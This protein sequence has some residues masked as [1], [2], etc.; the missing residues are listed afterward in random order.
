MKTLLHLGDNG[1][2]AEKKYGRKKAGSYGR[3]TSKKQKR[4]ASKAV[5]NLSAL[6]S[7]AMISLLFDPW[8]RDAEPSDKNVT[9][10]EKTTKNEK[11]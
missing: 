3:P 6:R 5:S 11:S 2:T 9:L 1:M 8:P 4:A 7:G 10:T